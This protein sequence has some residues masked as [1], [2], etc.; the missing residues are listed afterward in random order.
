MNNDKSSFDEKTK[1]YFK[2][3]DNKLN[4]KKKEDMKTITKIV[5]FTTIGTLLF[6]L[7]TFS[8]L[9]YIAFYMPSEKSNIDYLN[10]PIFLSLFE[11]KTKEL[12]VKAKN[13]DIEAQYELAEKYYDACCMSYKPF[14]Q[15]NERDIL[16]SEK[17]MDLYKQSALNGNTNAMSKL[18]Y[19]YYNGKFKGKE[20]YNKAFNL[21][22]ALADKGDMAALKKLGD[23]YRY[24]EGCQKDYKKALDIYIKCYEKSGFII[25]SEFLEKDTIGKENIYVLMEKE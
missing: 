16:Y 9:S 2:E 11:E 7:I 14:S 25:K 20:D 6:A 24:G 17:A 5:T 19:I 10:N 15:M 18:A 3:F 12:Q 21:Y 1:Q 23:M 13:G 8:I 4:D 22:N